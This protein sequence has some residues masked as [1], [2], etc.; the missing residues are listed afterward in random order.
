MLE[1]QRDYHLQHFH[2]RCVK[3]TMFFEE[4]MN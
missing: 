3:H 4:D 2:E 1:S